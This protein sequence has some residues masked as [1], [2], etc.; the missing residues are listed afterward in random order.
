MFLFKKYIL[1][2]FGTS[3]RD[4]PKILEKYSGNTPRDTP[5]N[6]Q[7]SNKY[8]KNSPGTIFGLFK[9]FAMRIAYVAVKAKDKG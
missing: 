6:P 8:S 5:R 4:I 9:H 2:L 1:G 7:D 3:P